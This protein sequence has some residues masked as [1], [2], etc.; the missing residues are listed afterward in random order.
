MDA[1]H[2]Q[3]GESPWCWYSRDDAGDGRRVTT[4]LYDMD[5][6]LGPVEASEPPP[7]RRRPYRPPRQ[8]RSEG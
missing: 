8:R 4:E 1:T 5:W 3:T 6:L 2:P 7:W